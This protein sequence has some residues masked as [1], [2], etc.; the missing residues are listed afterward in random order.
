MEE[1]KRLEVID[2][3]GVKN[4]K[5]NTKLIPNQ[6]ANTLFNFMDDFIYLEEMI[7]EK[8]IYPR[9]SKEDFSFLNI[10][11]IETFYI[12]MKCFCDIHLHMVS[13]HKEE[14]GDYA[15]G[16]TKEWGVRNGLQP[17]IYCNKN[18]SYVKSIKI[19]YDSFNRFKDE[20]RED[21]NNSKIINDMAESFNQSLKLLKPM[22]GKSNKTKKEKFFTDEQEW[23]YIPNIQ[24]DL[25]LKEVFSYN[26]FQE[27]D[28]FERYNKKL[29]EKKYAIKFE[30]NDVRYIIVESETH[31]NT[32][33]NSIVNIKDISDK[34]KYNLLTK[35]L[36]WDECKGDF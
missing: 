12:A 26:F 1:D 33:I 18:S 7:E 31:K 28:K 3:N 23:R 25:H 9:Y 21:R 20:F 5:Y 8:C 27:K 30:Y 11:N 4:T 14:F 13:K 35:I 34:E 17:I 6:S 29:K 22:F 36:V 24:N 16:L 10:P 19:S 2:L 15:I 32:L